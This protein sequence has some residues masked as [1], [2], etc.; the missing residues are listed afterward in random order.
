MKKVG[1]STVYTGFNY[2]SCL[3]AYASQKFISTLGYETTL[4][5]YKDGIV[6]GRDIRLKK[7][8]GMGIRTFW[9]PKLMKKTVSTYS[10]SLKKE[11]NEETKNYFLKFQEEKLR[12]KKLSW[13]K[14]RKF[15]NDEDTLACVCG[16]D[17]I[18]N[19][20]NIYID[21]IFYLR[22]APKNK[23]VAYAPS[24]GKN[25]IPD[26]NKKIIKK[27]V[28]DFKYISVREE[29][30]T[31]IVR[32]LIGREVQALID[33]TLLLNGEE[34]I[35]VS[36]DKMDLPEEY[37]LVY[38][39]D[40]PSEVAI[41]YINQIYRKLNI[42][43]ISI[44]YKFDELSKFENIRYMNAGPAQFINLIN[45]AKFVCTDSFHGM[46]FSANL[47]RPFYIFQRNYGT[48][49]DQS[50]RITS[51]LGKLELEDRF[52]SEV[53]VNKSIMEVNFKIDFNK[54]NQLLDRERQKSI[55][56]LKDSFSSIEN[57]K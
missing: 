40:K 23:R 3:Q 5:W 43:I 25:S 50:S 45:K 47:N 16:S 15:A 52:I 32:N 24:F 35:K 21:P 19:A 30:G 38:F 7:I 57:N 20:T 53:N 33:P 34:W 1:I 49:T 26:Y 17:Q 44:P 41:S 55:K 27:Y 6:K 28:S 10:N 18:W 13:S 12:V 39:L 22:F 37:I 9:R 36:D 54:S 2:G 42:P 11:I 14:L 56:F 51:I 29:Q 4:L 46:V 31:E 48:A 8:I